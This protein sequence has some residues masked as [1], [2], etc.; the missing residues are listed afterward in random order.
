[1]K[2]KKIICVA[3]LI[4]MVFSLA[5]CN[6]SANAKKVVTNL[7]TAITTYDLNAI[8]KCVEDI[9]DNSGTVY[10][11]D[12]YTEDYFVDL[13]SIAN[14]NLTYTIEAVSANEVKL[15]VNMPDVYTMYQSTVVSLLS[16]AIENENVKKYLLDDNNDA[17]L[18]AIALMIDKINNEGIS[19]VEQEITLSVSK[20]NGKY[21]I[22]SDDQLKLLL[23]DRLSLAQAMPK[24]DEALIN[25]D[26]Q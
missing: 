4:C 3:L 15:K 20:I 25:A 11:H 12:I 21:K 5:S 8:S 2:F 18:M 16:Q 7:M 9:P 13:Y 23:S 1:M 26:N 14:E 17:Q 6:S 24:T 10:K 19:T 22:K